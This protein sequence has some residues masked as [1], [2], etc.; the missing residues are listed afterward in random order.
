MKILTITSILCLTLSGCGMKDRA[1]CTGYDGYGCMS[2]YTPSYIYADPSRGYNSAT[3]RRS[4]RGSYRVTG[5][6]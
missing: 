4:G 6:R 2:Y 5:N 1:G 3:I